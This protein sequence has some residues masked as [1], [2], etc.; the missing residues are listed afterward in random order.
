MTHALID[1]DVLY[2]TSIY[3]LLNHLLADLPYKSES[4]SMLGAAKFMVGKKL[5]KKPPTR[6]AEI[7][8]AEFA[9]AL[10]RISALE[11]SE[12][13]IS[14]AAELEFRAQKLALELDGGESLLCAVLLKRQCTYM[15]SGDKR[16][17]VAL[18]AMS[19]DD[20]ANGMQGKFLCLEQVIEYLLSR[21]G[22][23]VLKTA[24]CGEANADKAISNCFSCGSQNTDSDS[25]QQGL[26][27]Y[28]GDLRAKAP[29]IL[30]Y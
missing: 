9:D 14:L 28:I 17:M 5:A 20:I 27:S 23:D 13:E 21:L 22:Y 25:C 4:C 8:L 12:E 1:T 24:V 3:G 6:G 7:A 26:Q 16:A 10:K 18:G 19:D 15:M 30:A 29:N 2:K 11:P